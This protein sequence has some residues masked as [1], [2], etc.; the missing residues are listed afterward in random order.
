MTSSEFASNSDNYCYRHPDRQSFV[1]CQRCMRTI[2]PECQTQAAV[3]VI[4]PECMKDDRA[5]RSPAQKKAARRWGGASASP[6]A[7][8][9]SGKP[10]VTYALL[11]ITSFISLVQL[12]PGVGDAVGDALLFAAAYLYPDLSGA[13]F[14]P[15]RM[16]T[17]LL[18]H[19][20]FI[21]LA[22]N[23]LGLWMGP[24]AECRSGSH[25]MCEYETAGGFLRP[26]RRSRAGCHRRRGSFGRCGVGAVNT[27][28]PSAGLL[29]G[30]SVR[31]GGTA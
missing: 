3:G 10:V 17:T 9:R 6:I 27:S 2:C 18:V 26:F 24:L 29:V 14:Q 12:I 23:M 7:A 1:L 15:W 19:G 13:P 16:L 21:H 30:Y 5:N 8:A 22:L 20:S 25:E 28:S 4:C 31:T 11:I